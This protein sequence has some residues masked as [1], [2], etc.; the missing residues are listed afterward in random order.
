[1]EGLSTVRQVCGRA[2]DLEDRS[3][4]HEFQFH[5]PFL[6]LLQL[7]VVIRGESLVS[8]R[9]A[10]EHHA[11]TG[12]PTANPNSVCVDGE[13]ASSGEVPSDDSHAS[14]VV[15]EKATCLSPFGVV[16]QEV[17]DRCQFVHVVPIAV[18][19][20]RNEFSPN[21]IVRKAPWRVVRGQYSVG[22]FGPESNLKLRGERL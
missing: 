8:Y 5:K 16:F 13:P 21:P 10:Y 19:L 15:E 7:L 3:T 6:Q 4:I 11:E 2:E 18:T 12:T 20:G 9:L 14:L 17:I 22:M 1:V